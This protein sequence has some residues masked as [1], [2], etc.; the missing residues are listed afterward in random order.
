MICRYDSG[1][2]GTDEYG[3]PNVQKTIGGNAKLVFKRVKTIT[4]NAKILPARMAYYGGSPQ[5]QYGID[6]YGLQPN[7]T[8]I[9]NA[10]LFKNNRQKT[11]IGNARLE[12][13]G[14]RYDLTGNARLFKIDISSIIGNARLERLGV[15]YDLTGNAKL[16]Y[17]R[18]KTITGN[19]YLAFGR[20][21]YIN[22]I[23]Y[24]GHNMNYYYN[25]PIN[26]TQKCTLKLANITK[27]NTDVA[28]E[29]EIR[30]VEGGKLR[31]FGIIRKVNYDDNDSVEV[32][33]KSYDIK[34]DDRKLLN[35]G[36]DTY[37]TIWSGTRTDDVCSDVLAGQ[38]I[39]EE[40]TLED[41]GSNFNIKNQNESRLATIKRMATWGLGD[42]YITR[43]AA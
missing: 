29:K 17:K 25:D 35:S 36:D 12:R 26:D 8:L 33:G 30:I 34:L 31:F 37:T 21:L 3:I 13:L 28:V 9:G 19:A 20:H 23:E 11:I 4:G 24:I 32:T 5:G 10:R 39:L 14:V 18:V 41:N 16:V 40:G 27:T 38:T 22:G 6:K 2:Y 42:Y 43:A 7:K 1:I 15:R